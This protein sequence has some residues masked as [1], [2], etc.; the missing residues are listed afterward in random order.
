MVH[1]Q[2]TMPHSSSFISHMLFFLASI[3]QL[4]LSGMSFLLSTAVCELLLTLETQS[5]PLR[6]LPSFLTSVGQ[7][8]MDV[9]AFSVA[10]DVALVSVKD[11]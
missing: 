1:S 9:H 5:P 2:N 6:S 4:P 7:A 8:D 10:V 11:Y 3:L